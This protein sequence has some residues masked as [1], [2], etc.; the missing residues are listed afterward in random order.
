M[1]II[2]N[3]SAL[4][5]KNNNLKN[6]DTIKLY[7]ERRKEQVKLKYQQSDLL[8]FRTIIL[9]LAFFSSKN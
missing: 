7:K 4:A 3:M 6:M 2:L 5:K 8:T 9:N 1:K